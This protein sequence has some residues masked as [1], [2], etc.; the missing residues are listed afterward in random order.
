VHQHT[1][2]LTASFNDVA[3][4]VKQFD[5][6]LLVFVIVNVIYFVG[7]SLRELAL[8]RLCLESN[9]DYRLDSVRLKYGVVYG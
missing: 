1:A 5:W 9:R 4:L 7:D 8:G 6:Q 3:Y 2:L